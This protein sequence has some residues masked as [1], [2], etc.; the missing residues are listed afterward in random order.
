MSELQD[1]QNSFQDLVLTGNDGFKGSVIGEGDQFVTTRTAIYHDAYRLRLAGVL[2]IDFP[3]L[4]TLAGDDQFE[5]IC[6]EYIKTYP[7]D[8]FSVRYFGRFMQEYLS[9]TLPYSKHRMLANIAGFEWMVNDVLD[10][11]DGH[12]VSL[13]ELQEISPAHWPTM[14]IN[15][16]PSLRSVPLEWSVPKFWQAVKEDKD[17]QAP[18]A[19]ADP[20]I[21]ILWR[22]GVEVYFR[23]LGEDEAWAL[24]AAI[25]GKTFAELCEGLC[26][27]VEPEN[28]AASIVGFLQNWIDEEMVSSIDVI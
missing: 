14:T 19:Y 6:Q 22:K 25:Q 27:W 10:A 15:L 24:D 20:V 2:K 1:L 3:G 26:D 5:N 23:S 28:V 8:H 4:H 13:K 21:W 9:K 17:P 18:T 11:E 7:S 16:H 12:V